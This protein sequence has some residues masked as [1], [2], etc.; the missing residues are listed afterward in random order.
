MVIYIVCRHFVSVLVCRHLYSSLPPIKLPRLHWKGW[1]DKRVASL[2]GYSLVV[3]CHLCGADIW[4]AFG[5]SDLVRGG[6]MYMSFTVLPNLR[7]NMR[8]SL[9]GLWCA[10]IIKKRTIWCWSDDWLPQKD[11]N[12]QMSKDL[13][14]WLKTN[15]TRIIYF[16]MY[17]LYIL[18]S[19]RIQ[20][21]NKVPCMENVKILK[22][23]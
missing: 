16:V 3:L 11:H 21:F 5:W 4:V 15:F 2:E 8:L 6:L 9:E 7:A 22:L 23:L 18:V 19:D 12:E 17:K 13:S 20:T 14:Y 10:T 1:P